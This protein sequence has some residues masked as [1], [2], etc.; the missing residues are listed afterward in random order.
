MPDIFKGNK[1]YLHVSYFSEPSRSGSRSVT[2]PRLLGVLVAIFITTTIIFA[3]FYGIEKGKRA[4]DSTTSSTT[5]TTTATVS[6]TTVTTTTT[7]NGRILC[8]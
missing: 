2:L 8:F 3:T 5:T 1:S 7:S 4:D 6:T